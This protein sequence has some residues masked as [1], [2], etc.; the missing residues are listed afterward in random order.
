MGGSFGRLGFGGTAAQRVLLARLTFAALLAAPAAVLAVILATL[1]EE[2]RIGFTIDLE[3]YRRYGVQLLAGGALYRDVPI[4]YPPLAIVPMLVPFVGTP[5][6]E[7]DLLAYT[8][9]F[10]AAA[11]ALAIATGALLW[12][13]TSGDMVAVALWGSLVGL[14]WVAVAFR[15]DLWPAVP[16]MVAIVVATRRPGLAGLALGVGTMLKLFPAFVLAVLAVRS[17][18][19]RDRGSLARLGAGF[20]LLVALTGGWAWL[21]AGPDSLDWLRYQEERGLQIESVG[22]SILLGLHVVAGLPVVRN[23][24]F[25][26][27]QIVAP[28]SAELVAISPV[29][30]LLLLAAVLFLSARRFRLERRQ[31]G[32]ISLPAL[33]LSA[34]AAIVAPLLA[35]KVLS[36]QYVVW[37]LPFVPFLR[38]RLRWLSLLIASLTTAVFTVDYQ[39]LVRFESGMIALLLARNAVLALFV[40]SVLLELSSEGGSPAEE[41]RRR[42]NAFRP[43]GP[44]VVAPPR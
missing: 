28:G 13:A 41:T 15:Y 17:I 24:E 30:Q 3:I 44:R 14:S 40:G 20:G 33:A 19:E 29:L 32:Q 25:G 10:L 6:A 34:V 36:M 42:R 12:R 5:A 21:V 7:L 22:A 1:S 11:G 39:G 31:L 16:T 18:V 43:A 9:R 38:L 4:E 8:W 23:H 37:L 35:S 2:N 26:A 27:V